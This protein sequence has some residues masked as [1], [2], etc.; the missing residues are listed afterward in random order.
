M[1]LN[2]RWA[3][4]RSLSA[5]KNTWMADSKN[6]SKTLGLL[7]CWLNKISV[8][9]AAAAT[10]YS[11]N[12][13]VDHYSMTREVCEVVMTNEVTSQCFGGPGI[14]VKVDECFLTRWKYHKGWHMWSGTVTLFG[15]YKHGTPPGV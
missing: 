12:T 10:E 4:H 13:A 15:I 2:H 6:I 3:C 9:T 8:T 1:H 11:P 7:F 5:I 14:Q